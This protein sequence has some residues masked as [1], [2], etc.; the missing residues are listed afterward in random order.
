MNPAKKL[1]STYSMVQKGDNVFAALSGG[2]DSV[3]LLHMLKGLSQ[4]LE[5]SLCAIH[6]NHRLRGSESQRDEQFCK[7]LC[8]KWGIPLVVGSAPVARLAK[9]RGESVELCARKTRYAFFYSK[10]TGPRDK[11]ATAH[12]LS[13]QAETILFRMAR[14]TGLKGLCGIPPVRDKIIR[15]LLECSREEIE[16]YCKAHKLAYVTDSSNLSLDYTRNRLRHQ[17]VPLLR[18]ENPRFEA[19]ISRMAATLRTDSDF[20]EA[21]AHAAEARIMAEG[22][23][24]R[25]QYLLLHEALRPRVLRRILASRGLSW[26]H[27]RLRLLDFI[28]AAGS[29]GVQL[30][31]SHFFSCGSQYFGIAPAPN[32]KRPPP[33]LS[34]VVQIS[35]PAPGESNEYYLFLGKKLRLTAIDVENFEEN[36][37]F[38]ENHLKN[39]LDYVRMNKILFL[40]YA[41]PKDKIRLPGRRCTK[42]LKNLWA[43]SKTEPHQRANTFL[44]ENASLVLWVENIGASEAAAPSEATKTILLL[45]MV[46]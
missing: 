1:I 19:G 45:E 33:L 27:S 38:R 17:V 15:P 40:R 42:T 8:K 41:R 44:L 37:K 12:T 29:G 24:L 18:A 46:E 30:S 6:L 34:P 28:I 3:A 20:L 13:D 9:Q 32:K 21:A 36:I 43:E 11:I 39:V 31:P 10:A 7:G 35:L 2:A 26:E 5:F 14:G 25:S 23:Y 22:K 4:E 16:S